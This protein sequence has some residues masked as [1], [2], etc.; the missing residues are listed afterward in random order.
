MAG[1]AYEFSCEKSLYQMEDLLTKQGPWQW[2]IRDCAWY[3]GKSW[4]AAC[5]P[6]ASRLHCVPQASGLQGRSLYDC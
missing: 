4:R 5:V 6:Q 1:R 2:R 3:F